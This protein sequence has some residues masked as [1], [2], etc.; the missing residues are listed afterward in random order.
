MLNFDII[1]KVMREPLAARLRPNNLSEVIG[2]QHLIN[3]NS[4]LVNSIKLKEYF[5][6]IFFGPPGT[7]KTSIAEAYA[8]SHLSS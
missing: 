2:Q 5:S 3:E 8:K 6:M 7:G 1:K 4:F